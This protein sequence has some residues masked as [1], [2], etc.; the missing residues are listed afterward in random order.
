MRETPREQ[1]ILQIRNLKIGGGVSNGNNFITQLFEF[2]DPRY[3]Q[4][5]HSLQPLL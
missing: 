3:E 4:K 1:K 5:D 2:L